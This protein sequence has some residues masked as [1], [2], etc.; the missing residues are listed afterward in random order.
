MRIIP[1]VIQKDIEDI[2]L[3]FQEPLKN[4]EGKKILITGANGMIPSYIVDVISEFNKTSKNP[5]KLILYNKNETNQNSRLGHLLEDKNVRF[6]QQDI[7]KPFKI[8]EGVDLI[9]HAASRANPISFKKEPIDTIEANVDGTKTLLNYAKE[10]KIEQFLFFS[11]SEVY[12]NVPKEDLPVT[13]KYIGKINQL[14][15]MA[16]YSESKR[17]SETLCMSF[18]RQYNTPTKLLRIFQTFGPGLRNDGKTIA[19]IFA[20]G[21]KERQINLRDPGLSKRSLSYISDT[22]RGILNV[23]F[24]G[25]VGEAYNI[26][27]NDNYFSIREIAE[28][29]KNILEIKSDIKFPLNYPENKERIEDRMPDITKLKE[30][31]FSPKISIEEGLIR[32]KDY[33][34]ETGIL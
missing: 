14:G 13:E 7:G 24:K 1:K 33:Y 10:N 22:T 27:N 2:V 26:G 28:I 23:M 19:D 25:K 11:S 8:K 17:F 16:C 3:E 30:L 5:A 4:F 20:K 21:I 6:I 9:L 34:Y 29:I 32:L 31:G 15:D 12:G 18:F